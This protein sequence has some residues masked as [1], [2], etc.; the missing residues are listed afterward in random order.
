MFALLL[1]ATLAVAALPQRAPVLID[2]PFVAQTESLCGGA[3]LTM[4]MRY[5]G[6]TRVNAE[7]FAPLIDASSHGIPTASLLDA[8]R[9]RGW[10]ATVIAPDQLAESIEHTRPVVALVAVGANTFHYVVI[11]GVTKDR[12]VLHDPARAPYQIMSRKDFESASRQAGRWMAVVLPA[13]AAPKVAGPVEC[14]TLVASAIEAAKAGDTPRAARLLDAATFRCPDDPAPWRERAG[15][16]FA[17]REYA[18]ASRLAARALTLD[19]GDDYT[20]T[21]VATSRYLAEKP[22]SALDAWQGLRVNHV[23]ITGADLTPQSLILSRLGVA[24]GDTLTTNGLS[25]ASHRLDD[26]PALSSATVRFAPSGDT[27]ADVTVVVDD[28]PRAPAGALYW[29]IVGARA[30]IARDLPLTFA[31]LFGAGDR[32]DVLWRFQPRREHVGAALSVPAP[33]GLPGNIELFGLWERQ[34][35]ADRLTATTSEERRRR[36]G[37]ALSDWA[38]GWLKWRAGAA[39]DR[40]DDRRSIALAASADVRLAAD[41]VSL[42]VAHEHWLGNGGAGAFARDEFRVAFRSSADASR[43]R[44]V[45]AGS[46]TDVGTPAPRALWPGA[47]ANFSREGTLRAHPLIDDGVVTAATFGRR[48]G[49]LTLSYEHPLKTLPAASIAGAAFVDVAEAWHAENGLPSTALVD[50]GV[51]LRIRARRA[52]SI[53]LDLAVGATDG[54]VRVSAG[55]MP[56]WPR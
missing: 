48:L 23:E 38:T 44:L 36:G 50:L 34:T 37:F 35:F 18:D 8:A 11:V 21:L 41:R 15:L 5:W 9:A 45:A 56:A 17:A 33:R 7:D 3:A 40:V 31:S 22:A 25:L 39:I 20:R 43:A 2:T 10:I 53:R 46:V 19:P 30:A 26:L 14:D 13:N 32:L 24:P 47:D 1:A 29:G 16:A 6:D 51:G 55:F 42:G 52:G 54:R 27:R 28:R 4:V 12:I 49:A